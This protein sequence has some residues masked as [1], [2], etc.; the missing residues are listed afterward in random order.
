MATRPVTLLFGGEYDRVSTLPAAGRELGIE[1][2]PRYLP[3]AKAAFEALSHD[4]DADG[5]E[6]SISF[7]MTRRSRLKERSDLVAL[8]VWIS[9]TF[10]HGNVWVAADSDLHTPADLAGR[11]VGLA[12]YGMTMAVWLRGT[13]Q[14]EDSLAPS[15]VRWFTG[16]DPAS[17]SEELL[18]VPGD[19]EITRANRSIPLPAQLVTGEL[20][21]V[22]TAAGLDP[23]PPGIRRLFADH[24]A[25]ERDYYRRTGIFPIMHVLVLR[26]EFVESRPD[27]VP[28]VLA[29]FERAK[30][31]ALARLRSP[32]VSYVT[33]PWTL[34]AVEEQAAVFGPDPWPYGIADNLPTLT[35]LHRYLHEQGLLWD[36]LPLDDYF[37]RT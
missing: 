11:R 10:R 31:M 12:E 5:G 20:D 26:R 29:A 19:V 32:S 4:T 24:V 18:R 7:Y 9:R 17:L 21:A 27:E 22:I 6:M 3:G 33:L 35:T 16:R 14:D 36:D 28:T 30:Q 23:R 34:A 25:V 8:P 13:F 15:D 37:A 1:I 2:N